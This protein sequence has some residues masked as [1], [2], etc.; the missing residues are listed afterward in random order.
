[1]AV[2]NNNNINDKVVERLYINKNKTFYS[3]NKIPR[4]FQ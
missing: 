4:R 1:M 2:G 3:H